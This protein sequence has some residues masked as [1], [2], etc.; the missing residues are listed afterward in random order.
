V[1]AT[2]FDKTL[3]LVVNNSDMAEEGAGDE[4]TLTLMSMARPPLVEKGSEMVS[5][6]LRLSSDFVLPVWHC[7]NF[8]SH[9]S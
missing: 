2:R 4:V 7:D 9:P 3:L 6:G 5:Q 1:L 8:D